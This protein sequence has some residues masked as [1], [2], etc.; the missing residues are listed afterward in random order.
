M[1]S[2][3][4]RFI[5]PMLV[6]G[7]ALPLIAAARENGSSTPVQYGSWVRAIDQKGDSNAIGK[8]NSNERNK[9][10]SRFE[11]TVTA[12]S[13]TS[14]SVRRANS[15]GVNTTRTFRVDTTTVVIRK[16]KATASIGEVG[17]GDRVKVWASALTGGT[18]KLIWDKSIW[19]VALRGTVSELN[20]TDT[21]F[22]L[23]IKRIE[24]ETKLTMTMTVPIT[25][26]DSTAYWMGLDSKTFSA[27]AN[28]QSVS[29]RGTFY[30]VGKYVLAKKVSIL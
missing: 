14:I 15:N 24:P 13:A 12:V 20:P 29:L 16:F 23:T 7:L 27:L 30:S 5:M 8:F 18:A 4:I 21:T 25:T 11:G 26:N 17:V 22:V 3:I 19:S 1:K 28:G 2:T 6:F 10:V 9:K